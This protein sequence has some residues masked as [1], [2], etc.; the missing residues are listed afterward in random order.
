MATAI[1]CDGTP[2]WQ[3][4]KPSFNGTPQSLRFSAS[5]SGTPVRGLTSRAESNGSVGSLNRSLSVLSACSASPLTHEARLRREFQRLG[6]NL[7]LQGR[8]GPWEKE[9]EGS[10]S[11]AADVP[12]GISN[13]KFQISNLRCEICNLRFQAERGWP[14]GR[15]RK[16]VR[17]EEHTSELQSQFH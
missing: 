12:F 1:L 9:A 8:R 10:A 13:G 3:G 15:S 14:I 6:V 2:P 5:S 17:S 11:E 4:V 16:R 7:P